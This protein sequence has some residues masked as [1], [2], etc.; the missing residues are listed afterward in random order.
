MCWNRSKYIWKSTVRGKN[1]KVDIW[2]ERLYSA[3]QLEVSEDA[4]E[5]IVRSSSGT[6]L[7]WRSLDVSAF[8]FCSLSRWSVTAS[9]CWSLGSDEADPWLVCVFGIIV[10][11]FMLD[12]N[13]MVFSQVHDSFNFNELSSTSGWSA[14]L[15]RVRAS[16]V[17]QRCL[18]AAVAVP[19]SRPFLH[20]DC[21]LSSCV[22]FILQPLLSV[23]KPRR[24]FCWGFSEQ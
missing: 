2:F 15:H 20:V 11:N 24:H 1:R 12:Q 4:V 13:L 6:V 16:T 21:S 14:A 3:A 9:W 10:M 17:F 5:G 8:L 22:S 19:R 23:S 18:Q 7:D